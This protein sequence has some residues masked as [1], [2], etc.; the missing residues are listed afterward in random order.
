MKDE[1]QSVANYDNVIGELSYEFFDKYHYTLSSHFNIKV[2][3][4]VRDP[5][6]RSWS[7][8][9]LWD[10]KFRYYDE[11]RDWSFSNKYFEIYD[12]LSKYFTTQFIVMEE[13]W[14][15]DGKEKEKLSN[16]INYPIKDLYRNAFSPDRG[17]LQEKISGLMDQC[18]KQPELTEKEYYKGKKVFSEVYDEWIRRFG[19]LPLNWGKPLN[20]E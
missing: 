18:Q 20:Y 12:K 17:H 13:L 7:E 2:G 3:I 9:T 15:G 4:I 19:K 1:Y 8:E 16:Y 14:E 10:N 11:P 6:R 5:V